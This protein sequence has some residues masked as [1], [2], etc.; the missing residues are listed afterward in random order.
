[1]LQSFENILVPIDHNANTELAVKKTTEFVQSA[2]STIHLLHILRP[3]VNSNSLYD[4]IPIHHP[5]QHSPECRNTIE[6]MKGW[7]GI[8]RRLMPNSE[9]KLH[10]IRGSSIEN[11]LIHKANQTKS[12]L[13]IIA[14]QTGRKRMQLTN[15]VSPADIARQ[16]HGAV[17]IAK[18]GA[19]FNKIKSI[20]LPVRSFIP[21]HKV[22]MLFPLVYHRGITI[23]L[24]S[25]L[26]K[27]ADDIDCYYASHALIETYR[28]LKEE[29][30]CHIIYKTI[31]RHHLARTLLDFTNS[32]DA[33]LLIVNPDEAQIWSLTGLRDVSDLLTARSRLQV[34][35]VDRYHAAPQRLRM[36]E[37]SIF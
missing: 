31:N 28:I 22:D 27:E 16:T 30:N 25:L 1:L 21:F 34:M 35:A 4:E 8:I 11:I 33:D 15:Q 6:I 17:L 12:Q 3:D 14:K 37:Y 24:V 18:P 23:Y 20:V 10:L 9:V 32:I 36:A 5:H 29:A 26:D 7:S 13:I 19:Y 2:G